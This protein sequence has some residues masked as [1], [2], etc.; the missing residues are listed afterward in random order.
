MTVSEI[1]ETLSLALSTVSLRRR[2]GLGKRSRLPS[3]F[4]WARGTRWLP[5]W[6]TMRCPA[7]P[8]EMRPGAIDRL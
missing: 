6:P 8:A 3:P 4:T 1:A 5:G 2:I 7:P